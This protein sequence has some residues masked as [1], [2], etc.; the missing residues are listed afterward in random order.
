MC[1]EGI[2]INERQRPAA[3][4]RQFAQAK[5]EQN[6]L[7]HP[8]IRTP[9]ALALLGGADRAPRQPPTE[10]R[11]DTAGP[12]IVFRFRPQG[13]EPFNVGLQGIH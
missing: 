6:A 5:T 9:A 2:F 12:G 8:D 10:F 13:K 11:K 7:F 1:R 3:H 4:L